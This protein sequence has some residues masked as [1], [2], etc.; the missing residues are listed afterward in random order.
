MAKIA[1]YCPTHDNRAFGFFDGGAMQFALSIIV[2]IL[3]GLRMKSLDLYYEFVEGK[4][5]TPLID[6]IG[7]DVAHNLCGAL[8]ENGETYGEP[9]EH[10]TKVLL[11]DKLQSAYSAIFAVHKND[12]RREI[13]VGSYSFDSDIKDRVIGAASLLS[14][15]ASY[16]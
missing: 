4:N 12:Y 5:A 15:Y 6:I 9:R 11:A 3:I 8:L 10:E 13:Q 1:A 2:P 7:G 14:D 16:N